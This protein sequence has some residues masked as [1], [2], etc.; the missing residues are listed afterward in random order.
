MLGDL[1]SSDIIAW[2]FTAETN[3][4]TISVDYRLAPENPYP[5]ALED[6][7]GVL[8]WA[9]DNAADLG[10]DPHR[11]ALAGDSAGGCL[12][13]VACLLSNRRNGPKVAAQ[14]MIYPVTGIALDAPSYV[15]N[16]D[17]VGLTTASM[18][19]FLEN[20]LQKPADWAD[21]LARPILCE[22]EE[23]RHLPPA[24]IHTAEFDPIRDDGRQYAALLASAG[25][26]VTYREVPGMIHGF[27]RLRLA[28]EAA[29]GEFATVCDFLK[30][31]LA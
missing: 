23:L 21:A 20:Y 29:A 8:C 17:A 15:E 27:Y 2:G 19:F 10:I 11:I 25:C 12:T 31:N 9:H 26:D 28:S 13:T 1:E 18:K 14:A 7:Y 24:F 30:T 6:T 22:M 16:A 4:V 3:A 5:A